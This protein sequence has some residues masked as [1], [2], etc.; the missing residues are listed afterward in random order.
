MSVLEKA[1]ASIDMD[2]HRLRRFMDEAAAA[3]HVDVIE[4]P[5]DLADVAAHLEGSPKAALF[6]KAGPEGAE[7]AGNVMG[8]ARPD[9]AG[10][11]LR[12]RKA[13]PRD[14]A[15][16]AEPAAG[17]R[18]D[19][20]R[21]ARAAGRADGRRRRPDEAAGASAARRRR[22]ALHLLHHRHRA[23]SRDRHHQCRHAPADAARTARG[24]RRSCRAQRSQGDLRGER[25]ARR[26]A[27]GRLR[28]RRASGRPCRRRDADA[29]RRTRHHGEPARRAAAGGQVRHQ[30]P[31]RAGRRRDDAR[32]LFRRTRPRRAGRA[33]WRVPRL[34]R[35]AED[36][37]GVPPHRDHAARR[38]AVP[39]VDHRRAHDGA[40]RHRAAQR[41]CAPR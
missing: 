13:H 10:L 19:P 28:G 11:R 35:R 21:S 24:R 31:Q 20:R 6:R 23:R 7:L 37:S 26:E 27:A 14:H 18:A 33:V 2:R 22:R 40:H 3:G 30:R 8:G 12:A 34:L 1:G 15:P 5:V 41:H 38:R 36:E 9:R 4:Q 39:D 32:G 16:A 17:R 25:A 29:G